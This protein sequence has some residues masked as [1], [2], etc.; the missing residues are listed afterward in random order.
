MEFVYF[1]QNFKTFPIHN[2]SKENECLIYLYYKLLSIKIPKYE[3]QNANVNN[4]VLQN[5]H[6]YIRNAIDN[7]L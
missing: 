2:F 7:N 6:S 3:H 4:N 5:I 1:L